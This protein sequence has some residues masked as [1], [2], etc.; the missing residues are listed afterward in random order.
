MTHIHTPIDSDILH[1]MSVLNLAHV[2]DGV[3]ELLVRTHLAR[4]GAQKLADQH[5]STIAYVSAPAQARAM[6]RLL[7]HLTE[8]EMRL[9][10]RGRNTRVHSCPSGCT[11]AQYHAATALEALFGYLWLTGQMERIETLFALILEEDHAT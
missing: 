8:A 3:Y 10:R 4:Q 2:G 7:P 1:A 9:Y 11:L 5:K 6:E